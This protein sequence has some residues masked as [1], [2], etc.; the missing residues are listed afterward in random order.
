[1]ERIESLNCYG[2]MMSVSVLLA[3]PSVASME[4]FTSA[5]TLEVVMAKV[6]DEEPFLM[7]T[8]AGTVASVLELARAIVMPPLGALLLMVTLPLAS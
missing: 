1:M 8:V 6:A 3:P 2:L 4:A 7:S 5:F